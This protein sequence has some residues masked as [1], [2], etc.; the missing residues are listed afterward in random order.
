MFYVLLGVFST[1]LILRAV[2]MRLKYDLH[3]IPSPPANPFL[4]HLLTLLHVSQNS[5]FAFWLRD[6]HKKLGY[7]KLMSVRLPGRTGVMITDINIVRSLLCSTT[8]APP[9]GGPSLPKFLRLISGHSPIRTIISTGETTPYVKTVRRAY[10]KSFS[11]NGLR[12]ILPRQLQGINKL[13]EHIEKQRICGKMDVQDIFLRASLDHIGKVGFNIEL[14]GLDRSNSLGDLIVTCTHHLGFVNTIP[15]FEIQML[16]PFLE[17]T[18]K[19]KRDLDALYEKWDEVAN[20]VLRH[21]EPDPDD[22]SLWAELRRVRLPET[23]APLSQKM[24]KGEL[25]TAIVGGV[26]TTSHQLGWTFALLAAHPYVVDKL[27]DELQSHGL[28]GKNARE[29]E[30]EDLSNLS[31]LDAVVKE[32]MRRIHVAPFVSGR[33]LHRDMIIEGYRIPKGTPL[34]IA[35]GLIMNNETQ[36]NDHLEFKPERW[37]EDKDRST[38]SYYIPFSIGNRNCVGNRLAIQYTKL[39]VLSLV[40]SYR[41][42][43]E[44]KT[45]KTLLNDVEAGIVI[46]A[47][48]GI[49]ITFTPRT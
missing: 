28:Y 5:S 6:W 30:F 10:F 37:L 24:L 17:S 22:F 21:G 43:I 13:M 31:Y 33:V 32:G 15:K 9:R 46:E 42:E 40:R 14:G 26:D 23:K 19:I 4:G 18:K 34:G 47:K 29:V 11:S 44:D 45:V 2:W 16:F 41:L 36:W 27:I 38:E 1:L 8:D 39:V 12:Q 3:K 49:H 35:G 7:P 20:N 48:S 25:A